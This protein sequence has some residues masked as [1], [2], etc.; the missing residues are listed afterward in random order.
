MA[1]TIQASAHIVVMIWLEMSGSGAKTYMRMVITGT[2]PEA[3]HKVPRQARAAW[4][5]VARG[6]AGRGACGLRFATG[7]LLTTATTTSGSGLSCPQVSSRPEAQV[8]CASHGMEPG[9]YGNRC[10]GCGNR[11]C[12]MECEALALKFE[13][14]VDIHDHSA[15]PDAFL[16]SMMNHFVLL[17]FDFT[18]V[19]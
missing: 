5:V 8:R 2:A 14:T 13:N 19:Q 12:G 4:N 7:S 3:I 15:I 16:V 9:G 11:K 1:S 6:T 18:N 17:M 10:S